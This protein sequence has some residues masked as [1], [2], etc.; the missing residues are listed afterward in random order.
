M[1]LSSGAEW[2]ENIQQIFWISFTGSGEG[3]QSEHVSRIYIIY[4]HV[5]DIFLGILGFKFTRSPGEEKMADSGRLSG[6]CDSVSKQELGRIRFC[7]PVGK[8]AKLRLPLSRLEAFLCN[9]RKKSYGSNAELRL[10]PLLTLLILTHL[11]FQVCVF[12][13][14]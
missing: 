13:K 14:W 10:M 4:S 8:S 2:V 9:A 11:K 7:P 5:G 6:C 3:P 12:Q 1:R